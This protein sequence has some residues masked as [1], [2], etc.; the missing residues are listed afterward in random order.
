MA[1]DIERLVVQLSA[2]VKQYQNALNRAMGITNQ[3]ARQVESRFSQMNKR[4]A[5]SFVGLGRGM[6]AGLVAGLGAREIGQLAD[7]AIK[8]ENALKVT[9]LA[10]EDLTR[11]YDSLR[12]SAMR[13]YAPLE[14]LAQLYSRLGL[15]QKALGVNIDE[16][17]NFTDKVAL[18]LR[19]QGTTAQEARGALIQLSQAMGAGIVRA[20]E[21]NSIV[22]GA[23]T[24]LRAAAAGLKEAGGEVSKL[25]QLV[26]DGKLS[27]QA[28][29]RAFEAGAPILD[30]MVESA[31][32]TLSQ[33]FTN[34]NNALVDTAKEFNQATGAADRF[35]GGVNNVAK[36][37]GDFDTAGFIH[38]IQEAHGVL[39]RFL[40]DVG[41]AQ[42]FN[43]LA[44]GLG[45]LE[46]GFQV[47]VD[48]KAARE[49]AAT[50]ER[51]IKLL[52]DRIALNTDLGID[53][54]DAIARLNEV[55]AKLTALR[56]QI[57][58]MPE[59]EDLPGF[60]HGGPPRRS[61]RRRP[62]VAA[63]VSIADFPVDPKGKKSGRG[64][65][66]P[67]KT[68]GDRFDE[69]IQAIRD[70]TAALI[71]EQQ[72][73]GK[74][75]YE[76]ER[77]RAALDL[78]QQALKDVRE[79]ARRK[80]EADW[81]NA[82]L[83]PEH[84]AR[85]NE[86]SDAY[87]RQADELRKIEEAQGSAESAAQEFYDTFKS[88]MIGAITGAE[89]FSDALAGVLKKLAE[90]VLNSAF[91]ALMGGSSATGSGGWLTGIFK[92]L[93]F[94]NGGYTGSGPKNKP[95]GIVHAGEVVWSQNDIARAGGV[96]VVE[97]MRKGMAMPA[98]V[99]AP[100]MP[101]LASMGGGGGAVTVSVPINIDATGADAAGLA[102][103]EQQ[104]Q[105]LQRDL[106]G[107]V[108]ATV[109]KAQSGNVKL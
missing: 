79:E 42:I 58:T 82:Q 4:V 73:V 19:V 47:N 64:P 109:R 106:P 44:H 6:V 83:T 87:A 80:G 29:F 86:A 93:G 62:K 75:Y 94:S 77:R 37:I 104:V 98:A 100:S 30:K 34:L 84:V 12:D 2:D 3:R 33:A 41:N 26:I 49:E 50:L 43:D 11:V 57:E 105:K 81:Q 18:A 60:N 55:S 45:V 31:N 8:I 59:Y 68:A 96:G 21:F 70:R 24:I 27:S 91:D 22:E 103:V 66:A 35:A 78:E 97:A 95:A 46:D 40:N 28:F 52:Q 76:Q 25:R 102:R 54:T 53:N 15:A 99:Q 14:T 7:S 51:E 85:I 1:T 38:K 101:S 74:S 92:G 88:G 13:N 56:G 32:V 39:E 10:G 65:K 72:I 69:D 90:M 63:P 71:Q 36:A 16:M 107:T 9:G 67:A 5:S 61:G 17:L 89:S 108:I 48:T 23:P 20:E